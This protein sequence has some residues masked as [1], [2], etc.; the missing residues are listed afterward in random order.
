MNKT[1]LRKI[2]EHGGKAEAIPSITK[3]EMDHI[4]KLIGT[5]TQ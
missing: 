1:P 4:R 5:A 3:M 2:P